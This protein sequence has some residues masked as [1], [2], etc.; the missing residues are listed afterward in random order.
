MGDVRT[1]LSALRECG[2][3]LGLVSNCAAIPTAC[4]AEI[5]RQGLADRFDFTLFSSEVGVRKPHPDI[6]DVALARAAQ[7]N[8]HGNWAA[9][10]FVFVGD[11]PAA[12]IAG[13]AQQGMR[14]VLVRTGNWTGDA[15]KLE[16]AP[17][18]IV[19]SVHDLPAIWT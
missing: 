12:D 14:T 16:P 13:P 5:T 18:L 1:T 11:T 9:G 10:D 3:A 4:R 15:S 7:C 19:D 2:I 6:Y 8:G 17:D